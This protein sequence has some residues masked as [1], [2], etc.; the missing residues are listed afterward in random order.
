MPGPELI[1]YCVEIYGRHKFWLIIPDNL[2]P[3]I[4]LHCYCVT[5][6]MIMS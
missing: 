2:Q 1:L 5:F 4:N 3:P 6:E